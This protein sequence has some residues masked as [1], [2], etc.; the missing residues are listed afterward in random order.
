VSASPRFQVDGEWF[1]IFGVEDESPIEE[2]QRIA[3][4]REAR[5]RQARKFA[6]PDCGELGAMRP[7]NDRYHPEVCPKRGGPA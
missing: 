6:C 4:L 2:A 5:E 3:H 7:G 1:P